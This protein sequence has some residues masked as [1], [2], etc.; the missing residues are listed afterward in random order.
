MP[1]PHIV[2]H[3]PAW[4]SIEEVDALII[5][6]WCAVGHGPM[7][8]DAYLNV[9]KCA[10]CTFVQRIWKSDPGRVAN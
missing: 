8:F 7:E 1:D 5:H 9:W 2:E 4:D 6:H 3:D 10:E